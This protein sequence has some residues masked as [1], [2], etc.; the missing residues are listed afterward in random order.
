MRIVRAHHPHG[1][2]AGSLEGVTRWTARAY[3]SFGTKPL[4]ERQDWQERGRCE[5]MT[6]RLLTL[7]EV[8]E[9]LRISPHTVRKMVR[10]DRLRPVRICRRLLFDQS[11]VTRLL[12]EV[13]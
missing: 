10:Q 4:P 11:E 12:T 7:T 5:M 3:H 13:K 9:L 6:E 1:D 2:Q 8:A